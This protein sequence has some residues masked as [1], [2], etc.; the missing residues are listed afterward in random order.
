MFVTACFITI[1]TAQ[2]TYAALTITSSA[3]TP[4]LAL[5]LPTHGS[6]RLCVSVASLPSTL[7]LRFQDHASPDLTGGVASFLAHQHLRLISTLNA[8]L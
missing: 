1:S 7:P 2:R 5:A 8:Q 6:Y 4:E 3:M